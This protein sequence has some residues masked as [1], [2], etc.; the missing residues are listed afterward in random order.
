MWLHANLLV[1]YYIYAFPW[2]VHVIIAGVYGCVDVCSVHV[3]TP[4]CCQRP[5]S[6]FCW[7]FGL[8]IMRMWECVCVQAVKF[9][10]IR[11]EAKA[12][13]FNSFWSMKMAK[14]AQILREID[15]FVAVLSFLCSLITIMERLLRIAQIIWI[16]HWAL[17]SNCKCCEKLGFFFVG[18]HVMSNT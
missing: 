11:G 5:H 14:V 16:V 3:S 17:M 4:I 6:P 13:Y 8:S 15:E 7:I 2:H 10:I 9:V 1:H 18:R 12:E